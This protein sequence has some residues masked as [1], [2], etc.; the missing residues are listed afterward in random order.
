VQEEG[1]EGGGERLREA[2]SAWLLRRLNSFDMD[3]HFAL[4]ALQGRGAGLT[5][6][7]RWAAMRFML[8]VPMKPPDDAEAGDR[9]LSPPGTPRVS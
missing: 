5:R 9:G 1:G 3:V 6:A 2:A 7:E 8:G 4:R